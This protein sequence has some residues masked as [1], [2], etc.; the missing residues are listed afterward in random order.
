MP[1][2]SM[3]NVFVRKDTTETAMYVKV[4]IK[5]DPCSLILKNEHFDSCNSFLLK[6]S[7]EVIFIVQVTGIMIM[8][9]QN[10]VF[11]NAHGIWRI[12]TWPESVKGSHQ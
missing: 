2:A 3:E 6:R 8:A 7:R 12:R 10:Q 9:T 1:S 11:N 4:F 5:S